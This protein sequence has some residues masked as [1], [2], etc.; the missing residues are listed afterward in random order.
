MW[1]AT[2]LKDLVEEISEGE[3]VKNRHMNIG[4]NQ[5]SWMRLRVDHIAL[6]DMFAKAWIVGRHS[7]DLELHFVLRWNDFDNICQSI[8]LPGI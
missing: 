5:K 1:R 4:Q 2:H 6:E 8:R 3:K 7:V